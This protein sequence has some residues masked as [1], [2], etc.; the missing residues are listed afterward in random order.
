MMIAKYLWILGSLIL[1]ILGSIH[2]F[3]TFFSDKFSSKNEGLISEM[4]VS[5]PILTR[6][7]TMWKAWIGFNASHSS[8]AMFIGIMNIYLAAVYFPV[9]QSDHFFFIFNI[10][11]VG[12]YVW[13]AKKY[14]FNIPYMGVSISLVCYLA[15][16]LLI[17]VN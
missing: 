13:L 14:W 15:A 5:H 16:Y 4:K 9:F 10:I 12:F 3:Y 11:T 17:L 8:G 1:L 2:L 7:T 6:G